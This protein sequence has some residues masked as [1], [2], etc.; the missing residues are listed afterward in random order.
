MC[1]S[2]VWG[3]AY[4]VAGEPSGLEARMAG[5]VVRVGDLKREVGGSGLSAGIEGRCNPKRGQV[6]RE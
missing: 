3:E 6:R 2:G 4:D 1:L 5:N